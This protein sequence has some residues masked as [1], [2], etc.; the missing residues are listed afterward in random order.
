M[1]ISQKVL[2]NIMKQRVK[3]DQGFGQ[4]EPA[5]QSTDAP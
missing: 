2:S 4:V 3:V 1:K 5:T